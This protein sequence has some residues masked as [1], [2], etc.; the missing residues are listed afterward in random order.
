V[1]LIKIDVEGHDREVMAG[2]IALIDRYHPVLIV[3]FSPE[4]TSEIGND[5][6]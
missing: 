1:R 3:E 5:F 6:A 4:H 2:A